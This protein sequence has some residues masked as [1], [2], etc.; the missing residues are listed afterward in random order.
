MQEK[1]IDDKIL[2]KMTLANVYKI[3]NANIFP[4]LNE[5]EMQFCK[6]IQELC[7]EL[8]PKVN[9]S[10]DVYELFPELGKR[11]FM[12]RVNAWKDYKP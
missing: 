4:M 5:E 7:I 12:Q 2:E 1:I 8:E 10:K 11:G 6:E 9:A 3:F